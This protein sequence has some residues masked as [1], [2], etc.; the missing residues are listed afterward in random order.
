VLRHVLRNALIPIISISALRLGLLMGGAVV[1]EVVFGWPGVGRLL[2]DAVGAR[3]Y[4]VIQ[5]VTLV[6]A[7]SVMVTNLVADILYAAV[8]PRIR[9]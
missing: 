6:L 3:D 8:N 4:P 9:Y 7:T 1:V 5:A 2:V